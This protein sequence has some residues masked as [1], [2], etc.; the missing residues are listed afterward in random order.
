ME[1]YFRIGGV[2]LAVCCRDEDR[3]IPPG[4]PL[5]AFRIAPPAGTTPADLTI[6]VLPLQRY[7]PPRG[8]LL[9]DSGVVW[10]LFADDGAY[11]I[12]CRS[13]LYG[14]VP[15]K[16]AEVRRDFTRAVI[17]V[18]PVDGGRIPDALEYPLDELLVNALVHLRGGVELHSCG[19][20]DRDGRGYVFAG[21]SGDGKTTTARLWLAAGASVVSDDRIILREENGV[22]WLYGTP[23]HGEAEISAAARAPLNHLFLIDKSRRSNEAS[24]P[25]RAAA[26]ARLFSCAFPPFHDAGGLDNLLGV[27]DRLATDVPI[28]RLSFSNDSSAV[29]FVRQL[30]LQG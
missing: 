10:T 2:T 6:E 4:P 5:S 19:V 1:L 26:V 7:E 14:D 11:R 8:P 15:Y 20:V 22:W 17:R 12:E 18:R 29:D 21:N 13:D 30:A 16:I 23:W 3:F 24:V 25:P 9:F 28:V 27:L